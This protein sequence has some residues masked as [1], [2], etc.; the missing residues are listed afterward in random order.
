MESP[1]RRYLESCSAETN[2][3]TTSGD[4]H[5]AKRK[6]GRTEHNV[7]E[8][9]IIAKEI[10]QEI[11]TNV[12]MLDKS[13]KRKKIQRK[14]TK[15]AKGVQPVAQEPG[16]E[17]AELVARIYRN[18]EIVEQTKAKKLAGIQSPQN[19]SEV[20]CMILNNSGNGGENWSYS[21]H[22]TIHENSESGKS[23]EEDA[24]FN[25]DLGE[26]EILS[27]MDITAASISLLEESVERVVKVIQE[28]QLKVCEHMDIPLS[29][30]PYQKEVRNI[31]RELDRIAHIRRHI[32]EKRRMGRSIILERKRV[33]R[34]DRSFLGFERSGSNEMIR[35]CK[36]ADIRKAIDTEDFREMENMEE[37]RPTSC[38]ENEVTIGRTTSEEGSIMER[39]CPGC[40]GC[41]P[42]YK[43]P[44]YVKDLQMEGPLTRSKNPEGRNRCQ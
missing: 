2:S 35:N 40:P 4:R 3:G 26:N 19:R 7:P 11:E 16:D 29:S 9:R 12:L 20:S 8:Q 27:V 32:E 22:S 36:A 25:Y 33:N 42:T 28:N 15:D 39:E 37:P 5:L 13:I 43:Q 18:L 6:C 41:D 17:M 44:K 23:S 24:G 14:M 34:Q 30:K 1:S 10:F 38:N 21:D 31:T